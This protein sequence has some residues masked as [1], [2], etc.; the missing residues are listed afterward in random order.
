MRWVSLN[1]TAVDLKKTLK[2]WECYI[3]YWKNPLAC[4]TLKPVNDRK[5]KSKM[6]C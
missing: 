6:L 1:E 5:R 2:S 3:D 4:S